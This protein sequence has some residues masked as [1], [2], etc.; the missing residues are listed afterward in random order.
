MSNVRSLD[1]IKLSPF[2]LLASMQDAL[3]NSKAVVIGYMDKED[4]VFVRWSSMQRSDLAF[5]LKMIDVDVTEEIK[6]PL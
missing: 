3:E 2:A 5:I 1:G 4:V 6:G